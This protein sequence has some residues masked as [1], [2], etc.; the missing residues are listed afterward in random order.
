MKWYTDYRYQER[1]PEE[2]E[3]KQNEE[4]KENRGIRKRKLGL[5]G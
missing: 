4:Q 1:L 5:F 2:V 3:E